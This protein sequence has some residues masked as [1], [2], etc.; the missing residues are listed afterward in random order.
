M[1]NMMMIKMNEGDDFSY[2]SD[3]DQMMNSMLCPKTED[4]SGK[5]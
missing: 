3:D 1:G 4:Q 2:W 5:G